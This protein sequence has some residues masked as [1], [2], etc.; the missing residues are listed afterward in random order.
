PETGDE[1]DSDSDD[2][3][4]DDDDRRIAATQG[5]PLLGPPEISW[6]YWNGDGWSGLLLE[7]D[8]TDDFTEP[9]TV[10]FTVPSDLESSSFAGHEDHWVR[11][12]LVSGSYGLPRY[13]ITSTGEIGDLIERP[14]PPVF[15]DVTIR[16]DQRNEPF[17]RVLTYNNLTYRRIPD[18]ARQDS[19]TPFVPPSEETQTLYLGFDGQLADGPLNLYVPM[20]DRT[21][22]RGFDSGIRWEYCADPQTRVWEKLDVND[23][24]EGLTER[25]I[26]SLSVPGGTTAFELFGERRHWIRARVTGDEF[27]LDPP[28]H[29][30]SD[31]PTS[32]AASD[33]PG[34]TVDVESAPPPILEGVYPNTQ[35]GYNERTVRDEILGSSD[36]G[37]G[38]TVGCEHA[39]VTE[40]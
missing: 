17:E 28:G 1:D 12:R 19:F 5:G 4:P 13:G 21:Y 37:G 30:T 16:Y 29:H 25:G 6:E 10:R 31:G 18:A 27:V 33:R 35:W 24:T 26:V 9:G 38:Q 7:D 39:P 34:R 23:G 8:G 14:T 2:D 3:G 20:V 32:G 11:A 36:G 22:P 40:A 15:G